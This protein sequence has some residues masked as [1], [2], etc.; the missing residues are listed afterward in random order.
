MSS[1]GSTLLMLGIGSCLLN[2]FGFEF[3]LLA[4]VD[5]WGTT[6]GNILRVSCIALGAAL[7]FVGRAKEKKT[8]T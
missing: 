1:F 5:H 6:V 8:S 2:W 3:I 7:L 4:W